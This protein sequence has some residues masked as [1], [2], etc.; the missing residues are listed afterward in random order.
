M[1]CFLRASKSMCANDVVFCHEDY[2]PYVKN[3]QDEN[4]R[5]RLISK[6][7]KKQ[8]LDPEVIFSH[9]KAAVICPA[10]IMFD[11]AARSDDI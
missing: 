7:W 3:Y 6:L 5:G 8:I 9:S 2:C 4:L 10:E 1:I 11:L